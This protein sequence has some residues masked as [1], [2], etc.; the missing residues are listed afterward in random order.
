[1]NVA[2][3]ND[4][5]ALRQLYA[6]QDWARLAQAAERIALQQ[7]GNGEAWRFWGIG[8]LMQLRGGPDKLL[9]A[10]L[11]EDAEAGLWLG[12]LQ[13]FSAHPHGTVRVTD[14][15]TQV[16]LA[17]IRRSPYL[18][19]PQEVHIETFAYCNAKCTFCP[20]PTM[21]RQG[22]KMPDALIDK[23][24][25][26]LKQIPANVPFNIA[27]FKVNEPFLDKRIFS[28]CA[29]INDQLPN[30]SIRLF[31]NGS[32]LTA[33][34]VEKISGVR[35]VVHLWISLNEVEAEAY[36][37]LMQLP[38]EKTLAKLDAL[39]DLVRNGGFPHPV[40]ISRVTDGSERDRVFRTFVEQRY[41]LFKPFMIGAGNWTGQVKA[42]AGRPVPGTGCWRW[43]EISIMAS[44]K[45]ALCC[46]DGEG[47]HVIGDVNTQTVLGVYNSPGYRKMRKYTFP[48]KAAAAPCDTCVY[49]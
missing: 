4:T 42:G 10:S 8:E 32:P 30:A 35:K 5:M 46:M 48:R 47:K 43:F 19:Y 1:M 34:I 31:T 49:L 18:D 7:S 39:H 21:E 3:G 37:K 17:K 15:V 28:V 45:V 44:G 24:I 13:E 6:Q 26:D 33:N 9:R 20:Y 36:E 22:D 16:E 40:T 11:L 2:V 41:P 14:F 23:I 27:P 29:K 12:M 38:L 25:D